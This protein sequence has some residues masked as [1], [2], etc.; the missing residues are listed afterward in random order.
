MHVFVGFVRLF[1]LELFT[2]LGAGEVHFVAVRLFVSAQTS[3]LG[4]AAVAH[5]AL[6]RLFAGVDSHVIHETLAVGRRVRA[7][8]AVV[9]AFGS[10]SGYV[11][12]TLLFV[13]VH[14]LHV[15]F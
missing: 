15:V 11:C 13:G 1:V 14:S 9:S 5:I 4:K 6:E 10:P 12:C 2:T 7:F 3:W 8:G